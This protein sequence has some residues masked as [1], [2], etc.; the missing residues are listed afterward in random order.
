M[1]TRNLPGVNDGRHIKLK[2]SPPSVSWLSRKCGSL[3]VSQIYWHPRPI[4]GIASPF[5]LLWDLIVLASP[6]A[7]CRNTCSRIRVSTRMRKESHEFCS[8]VARLR[9]LHSWANRA[10]AGTH[11]LSKK[12]KTGIRCGFE[13]WSHSSLIGLPFNTKRRET[14]EDQKSWCA[15]ARFTPFWQ[16]SQIQRR[17]QATVE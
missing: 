11:L 17:L 16:R 7:P 10:Y 4:T 8:D 5:Q 14:V 15:W 13:T 3:D 2:T 6:S 9:R 12:L 1:C